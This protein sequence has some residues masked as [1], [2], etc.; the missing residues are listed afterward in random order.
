[1]RSTNGMRLKLVLVAS[2]VALAASVS[3]MCTAAPYE[4]EFAVDDY[5]KEA[6]F[7]GWIEF[8]AVI[9]NTGTMRDTID[10]VL[11]KEGPSNWYTDICIS[12]KCYTGPT[13]IDLDPGEIDTVL[14]NVRVRDQEDVCLITL[15]GTMRGDPG[16][17]RDETF[18]GFASTPSILIVDDDAGAG[19]ETYIEAAVDSAGYKAR[20]WDA[21]S[22]GRPGPVQLS[23]YWAVLWT[24]ADGDANYL[25]GSDENDMMTYLDGGGNL[26]LASMNFL[27]SR[28]GATTFTGDY[29]H[30][31]SWTNNTGST[32]AGGFSGDP[33]SDGMTLSLMAG[34]FLPNE[35]DNMLVASPADSIFRSGIGTN[36]L[37]VDEGG[38]RVVF[39]SFPFEV[40]I[41][42][43][44]YPNNQKTLISRVIEWFEPPIAGIAD[45]A[46]DG[47]V[48]GVS[49]NFP[50]P[51]RE[52]THISFAIARSGLDVS[53][54][55]YN[56]KGQAVKIL[57]DGPAAAGANRIA[58]DGTDE[59]GS[60]VASGVYFYRLSADGSSVVRPMVLLK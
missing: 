18:A 50:N 59:N 53:L 12:G 28:S 24:T 5:A 41:P 23:S 16:Q 47:T 19:Y 7:W 30:I 56:V 33:I 54:R 52:A 46:A 36:G 45:P 38:H 17:I 32:V 44:P 37:K 4:F 9:E 22:L 8:R 55:V 11:T 25:A 58:W 31:T 49:R 1:M 51:F 40:V 57:H 48:L 39:L 2:A 27:S 26:L 43:A 60:P 10:L 29:L 14:V 6:G 3:T 20:M 34:P 13:K 42:N 15:T 35:S 21:D